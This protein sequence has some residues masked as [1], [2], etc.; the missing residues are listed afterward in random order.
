MLKHRADGINAVPWSMMLS[1]RSQL[2]W[3][4]RR[5]RHLG[6]LFVLLLIGHLGVMTL[7]SAAMGQEMPSYAMS[8]GTSVLAAE[9]VTPPPT[10]CAGVT[11]SCMLAWTSRSS[12]FSPLILAYITS[13]PPGGMLPLVSRMAIFGLSLHALG[14]PNRVRV[15]VLFQVFRI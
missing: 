9:Q 1:S 7:P 8:A 6:L 5:A 3:I 14:P 13:P 11:G 2:M 4:S 15:Q 10:G 12:G